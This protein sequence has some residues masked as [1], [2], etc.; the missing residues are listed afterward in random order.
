MA[1]AAVEAA[2]AAIARAVARAAVAEV[3]ER[4]AQAAEERWQEQQQV[5]LARQRE[6]AGRAA[7][8]AQAKTRVRGLELHLVQLA[9]T[10]ALEEM[11][12]RVVACLEQ[13]KGS[14]VAAMQG[15]EAAVE[16][17]QR[18]ARRGARLAVE[19]AAT[20]AWAEAARAEADNGSDGERMGR[21]RT[22]DRGGGG[23]RWGRGR[24]T[25]R[26]GGRRA[27]GGGRVEGWREGGRCAARGGGPEG[28]RAGGGTATKRPGRGG[29]TDD[30]D[31]E[32]DAVT[33]AAGGFWC[34][35]RPEGCGGWQG[36]V[37][38]TLA[39]A[40]RYRGIPPE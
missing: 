26:E 1:A 37:S 24:S 8:A 11:L 36:F 4:A 5:V 38:R 23:R 19:A 27:G 3:G 21:G 6:T 10:P 20:R 40:G 25:R 22:G 7:E 12:P 31:V 13:F 32:V 33:A 16:V 9:A 18:A 28:R 35:M 14:W 39:L 34:P 15:R 2:A 30:I 29:A 17:Q